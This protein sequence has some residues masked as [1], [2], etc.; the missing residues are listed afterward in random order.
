MEKWLR[1]TVFTLAAFGATCVIRIYMFCFVV[2]VMLRAVRAWREW[3]SVSH[4]QAKHNSY[5]YRIYFHLCLADC[6][7]CICP[8]TYR[9]FLSK[10]CTYFINNVA[11][12]CCIMLTVGI[13]RMAKDVV[14]WEN[15][16]EF[17]YQIVLMQYACIID[18]CRS[19][20]TFSMCINLFKN[21][22]IF[23]FFIL[24]HIPSLYSVWVKDLFIVKFWFH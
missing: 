12:P 10:L 4:R 8:Y 18:V 14:H 22:C 3:F 16:Y 2:E 15:I 9:M 20:I 17:A 13:M 7:I 21:F 23:P 5:F 19:L 24:K 11:L 1:L 6:R